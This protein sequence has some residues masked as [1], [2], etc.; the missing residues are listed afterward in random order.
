MS[1]SR[2]TVRNYRC[3]PDEQELELGRI[4]VVLGRNNSGK[5]A[6]VR[7]PLVMSTGLP[8]RYQRSNR[9]VQP[10]DLEQLGESAPSFL[11]LVHG[12]KSHQRI[13]FTM[14]FM[15]GEGSASME[16]SIQDIDEW[17]AQ[18][19]DKL[20]I[21]MGGREARLRWKPDSDIPW[22]DAQVYEVEV[23]GLLSR[24]K[25]DF[26]GFFPDFLKL[27]LGSSDIVGLSEFSDI[28]NMFGG[29]R[30]L[31]PFRKRPERVR[32]LPSR[33]PREV[34]PTGEEALDI[35]ANDVVRGEGGVLRTLNQ[36][37]AENIP[38]WRVG[39]ND[40][41][42]GMYS[43]HL[44]STHDV[45]VKVSLRDAGTG[46]VQML[47][48]LVQRALDIE[49]GQSLKKQSILEIVEEPELHL[50]PSAHADVADLFLSA[51]KNTNVRFLIETHSETFLLRLRRRIAEGR[52]K[53]E[54]ISLYFV[55][56]TD[57]SAK[58]RRI[59]IDRM[60]NLDYWPSGVFTE[61]FEET[62]ALA[63]AQ[64]ERLGSDARQG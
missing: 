1:L 51:S 5:S 14:D 53:P 50:H 48:I 56:H 25:V 24:Q 29:V 11:D 43:V 28:A 18:V 46:V 36:I 38:G 55:E 40:H 7:A 20:T 54:E 41:G 52:V 35:L 6:L 3:F 9:S 22:G 59:G 30:Y 62:R 19:V 37:L 13:S 33:A 60:G 23:G 32:S 16:V 42:A 12:Q 15:S 10:L 63:A 26:D 31:G 44:A 49:S 21:R 57:G 4:T 58:A 39:I 17:K 27:I 2:F 34:G 64:V 61:D 45:S 47:P 8:S